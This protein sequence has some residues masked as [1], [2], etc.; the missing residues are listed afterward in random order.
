[1]IEI[2]IESASVVGDDVGR[3]GNG[4]GRDRRAARQR[5]D[6]DKAEGV[7]TA[8]EDED[9]SAGIGAGKT[10]AAELAE[11]TDIREA[12]AQII[13]RRTVP[14]DHLRSRMSGFEEGL[15]VFFDRDAADIELDRAGEAGEIGMGRATGMKEG[16]IDAAFPHHRL[17]KTLLRKLAFQRARCDHDVLRGAMEPA[18]KAPHELRRHRDAR[19]DIFGKA[20]VIGGGEGK[21]GIDAPA[22]RRKA[23]R[24][25][26]RDMNRLGREGAYAPCDGAL[27]R[28]G[29]ADLAIGRA[30]D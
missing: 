3:A 4:I 2:G 24:S 10:L 16:V 11:E 27:A 15:D 18:D 7:G 1:M 21:A 9:V 30:G 29:Q 6:D 13:E 26:G 14:Y 25:L 22:P 17:L 28:E 19:R 20:R 5:F 12:G 23:E 8:G